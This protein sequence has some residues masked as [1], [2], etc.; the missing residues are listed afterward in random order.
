MCGCKALRVLKA[1]KGL[2]LRLAVQAVAIETFLTWMLSIGLVVFILWAAL[3]G[4]TRSEVTAVASRWF[5]PLVL[6]M[7]PDWMLKTTKG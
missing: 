3:G 5:L 6:E 4:Q 2:Q 7:L 1:S